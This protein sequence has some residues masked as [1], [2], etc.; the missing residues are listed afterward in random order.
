VAS[1]QS[2]RNRATGGAG[3]D[4]FVFNTA[5]TPFDLITGS[6]TTI[7]DFETGHDCIEILRSAFAAPSIRAVRVCRPGNSLAS[8]AIPSP[9]SAARPKCRPTR[10]SSRPM[11]APA[12]R[13]PTAC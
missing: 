9:I 12:G 3:V 13:M 1:P 7:T 4:T 5:P 11:S 6:L 10:S 2:S 8:P